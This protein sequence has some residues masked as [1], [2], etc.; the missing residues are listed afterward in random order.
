MLPNKP[1]E[2]LPNPAAAFCPNGVVFAV[3]VALLAPPKRL[4]PVAVA[5]PNPAGLAAVPNPP[6]PNV[7]FMPKPPPEA[8]PNRRPWA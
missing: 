7:L 4:W 2:G 1:D 3:A 6:A 5:E 8:L